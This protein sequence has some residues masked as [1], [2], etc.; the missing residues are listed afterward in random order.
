M[1]VEVHILDTGRVIVNRGTNDG[2]VLESKRG[3]GIVRGKLSKHESI[4]NEMNTPVVTNLEGNSATIYICQQISF[5]TTEKFRAG[6]TVS[7]V[8]STQF[9]DVWRGFY[10]LPQLRENQ[11]ILKVSPQQPIIINGY[12]ETTS[13]NTVIR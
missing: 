12:I 5:T 11:V 9:R 6:N 2:V 7:Q 3:K 10:L 13:L 8:Q 1:R 4:L